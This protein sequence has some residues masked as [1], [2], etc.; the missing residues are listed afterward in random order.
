MP[1]PKKKHW[2]KLNVKDQAISLFKTTKQ[3]DQVK[4]QATSA[5]KS[6]RITTQLKA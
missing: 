5:H 3:R 1:K 6:N 2:V 4:N